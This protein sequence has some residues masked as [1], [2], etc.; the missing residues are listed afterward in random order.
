MDPAPAFFL[1]GQRN[2]VGLNS[3]IVLLIV[4][5][6]LEINILCTFELICNGIEGRLYMILKTENEQ[7]I[8]REAADP[9]GR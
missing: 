1:V 3:A 2:T 6:L 5:T 4:S 8:L 7:T 9:E